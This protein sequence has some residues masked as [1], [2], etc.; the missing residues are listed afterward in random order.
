MPC[1][2]EIKKSR[3]QVPEV[4]RS[5]AAFTVGL[6]MR[7]ATL[8]EDGVDMTAM[9]LALADGCRLQYR[10]ARL[11]RRMVSALGETLFYTVQRL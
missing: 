11:K 9:M 8:I 1:L 2:G 10:N 5:R 7:Q 6:V 4:H 3:R